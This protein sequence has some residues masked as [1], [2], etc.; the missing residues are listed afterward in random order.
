MIGWLGGALLALGVIGTGLYYAAP[1]RV[2][3]LAMRLARRAAGLALRHVTVDGHVVPYLTGGHG[4][5]LVLLHGFGA[6]KDNWTL[7]AGRL[8]KHFRVV[9]PDLPGFG[10]S[11]R[12]E[13]A[14]YGLDEQL[15]RIAGFADALGLE[16]FH[17]G[18]N[19]M[20]GYLAALFAA[21]WPARVSSLWLLAP[22]G[23]STAQ[24]SELE[25][26][27]EEGENPLLVRAP[28]D[29]D[30]LLSM[31]FAHEPPMPAQF[32]RPLRTRAMAEAP[33]NARLFAELFGA[34]E[35]IERALAGTRV[36][37]L[38]VWGEDDR[39]L[40]VSGLA[41]L[42]AALPGAKTVRMAH[43][44][45]VPMVERPAETAADFLRFQ[46]REGAGTRRG[47]SRDA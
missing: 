35:A 17:L 4:D 21:R 40:H 27:I 43:T 26:R 31:C 3:E 42:A 19:S 15:A 24:R 10:D 25:R 29:F 46:E 2:L 39:I 8:T 33:F 34:P 38:V 5:P 28:E 30:R 14:R 45:H 44:G 13:D 6:N 22:A 16:R 1:G 36:P 20:G 41:A 37:T 9:A 32:R 18:G 11:S 47:V 7:I 12:R 23:V